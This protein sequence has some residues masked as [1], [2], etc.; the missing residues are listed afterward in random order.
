MRMSRCIF[1]CS[2]KNQDHQEN[3]LKF[4][5]DLK[6]PVGCFGFVLFFN[7]QVL[8]PISTAGEGEMEMEGRGSRGF[9][10]Q[11]KRGGAMRP[12]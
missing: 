6:L 10:L 11:K 5:Y 9:L 3:Y 7:K 2:E 1:F 4:P 12:L 8:G